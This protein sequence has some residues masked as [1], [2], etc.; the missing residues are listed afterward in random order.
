MI[1]VSDHGFELER[2]PDYFKYSHYEAP[3][4]IFI[5]AGPAF[6]SVKLEALSVYDVMP[7]MTR[8]R[9]LPVADDLEGQ[10]PTAALDEAYLGQ[11]PARRLASYGTRERPELAA[12]SEEVDAE[13]LDRLRAL[14]YIQ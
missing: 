12:G 8:L 13:M 11:H 9:G 6:R 7:L 10:L 14:G 2:F 3:N 1:V 4:G 5:G